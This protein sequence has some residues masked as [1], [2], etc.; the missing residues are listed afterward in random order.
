MAYF[1]TATAPERRNVIGKNR[2]W[3]FF[4]LSNETH[5]ANRRQPAQPR[6]KILPTA[7][8][9]V[10]GIP[11][12]PSRDPI[13]ERGGV[14]LYAMIRNNPICIIDALGLAASVDVK[15][16]NDPGFRCE[17]NY[18]WASF[19][20][21]FSGLDSSKSYYL[22]VNSTSKH[23]F[24]ACG[25]KDKSV[26]DHEDIRYGDEG[27]S[28]DF[29]YVVSGAAP[30]P[31]YGPII[32]QGQEP[33]GKGAGRPSISLDKQRNHITFYIK[34]ALYEKAAGFPHLETYSPSTPEG[35]DGDHPA[36]G[37]AFDNGFDYIANHSSGGYL[38]NADALKGIGPVASGKAIMD[39]HL[40]CCSE[41]KDYG[42]DYNTNPNIDKGENRSGQAFEVP[43][44]TYMQRNPK[45]HEEWPK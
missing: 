23:S 15:L 30:V 28:A 35:M 8:K 6:R 26:W 21:I 5:R 13:G 31:V 20:Y 24:Q 38:H 11:Y 2:V 1:S 43:N 22:V 12:W 14:N 25:C 40:N 41:S 16:T 33:N 3:D 7:T 4:R 29:L 10:S 17:G 45:W 18:L 32:N 9:P 27:D 42:G 39:I 44:T 19:N 36:N 34:Y 37:T